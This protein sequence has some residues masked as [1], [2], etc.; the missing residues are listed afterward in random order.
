MRVLELSFQRKCIKNPSWE[1]IFN[2]L[3]STKRRDGYIIL[4]YLIETESGWK[5]Q[6]SSLSLEFDKGSYLLFFSMP[7]EDDYPIYSYENINYQGD[8]NNVE[9]VRGE[10]WS[11]NTICKDLKFVERVFKVFFDSEG[12]LEPDLLKDYGTGSIYE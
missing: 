4:E 1:N 5:E 11:S 6:D 3:E 7:R 12:A 10:Y 2:I 8:I 9:L